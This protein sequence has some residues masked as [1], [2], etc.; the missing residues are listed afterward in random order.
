MKK[1][2]SKHD[3]IYA[4][5]IYAIVKIM[6]MICGLTD[7]DLISTLLTVIIITLLLYV[8]EYVRE[9]FLKQTYKVVGT[10]NRNLHVGQIYEHFKGN[11]YTIVGISLYTESGKMI[12]SYV[13]YGDTP[14]ASNTYSRPIFMFN[15][16]LEFGTLRRDRFQRREDLENT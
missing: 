1:A 7:I 14:N 3:V 12:V 8:R 5:V 11:I 2:S 13:P 16:I 6:L 15:E 4:L 9:S 10:L